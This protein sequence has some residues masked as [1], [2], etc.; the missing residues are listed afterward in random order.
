MAGDAPEGEI[1]TENPGE[2]TD[3]KIDLLIPFF[4]PLEQGV[5]KWLAT[6]TMTKMMW[7]LAKAV[8]GIDGMYA[9]TNA[10]CFSSCCYGIVHFEPDRLPARMKAKRTR[11]CAHRGRHRGLNGIAPAASR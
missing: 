7:M 3:G 4:F 8:V 1:L 9:N 11:H 2:C 10:V 5:T 6:V